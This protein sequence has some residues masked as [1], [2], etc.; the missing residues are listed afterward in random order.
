VAVQAIYVPSE[1]TSGNVDALLVAE[2]DFR[3]REDFEVRFD[4]RSFV[5]RMNR[6]RYHGRGWHLAGFEVSEERK[7]QDAVQAGLVAS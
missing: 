7:P 6:V 1:D 2:R 4:D 3:P 5:I